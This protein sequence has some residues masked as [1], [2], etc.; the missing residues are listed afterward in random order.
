MKLIPAFIYTAIT[1]HEC[2]DFLT[3]FLDTLG[4]KTTDMSHFYSGK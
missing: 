1:G 3:F 2:S 4:Q